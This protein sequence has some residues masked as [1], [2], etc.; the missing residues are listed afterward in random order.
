MLVLLLP[1]GGI[2]VTF[3]RL[4]QRIG[5][6]AW[7]RTEGR[8]LARAAVV[9][10]GGALAAFTA[11]IWWPNGAYRPIQPNEKGT[12][13]GALA[14][15]SPNAIATGRPG[16]TPQRQRQL[17]GAPFRSA[18]HH[19]A[20]ART[21]RRPTATTGSTATTSGA[22]STPAE[23]TRTSIGGASTTTTGGA[24]VGGNTVSTPVTTATAPTVTATTPATTTTP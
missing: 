23:T 21:P 18:K 7:R 19:A 13:Q 1:I 6:G 4:G 2:A 11:F 20:P 8:P 24:T 17:G 22:A 12:I 5:V 16:L 14:Q 3:A 15:F 9:A 10:G